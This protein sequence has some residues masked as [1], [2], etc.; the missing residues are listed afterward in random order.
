ME[1]RV[2][3]VCPACAAVNRVPGER[4]KDRALCGR[5]HQPLF[6]GHPL[7]LDAAAFERH[8]S[9]NS[10]P[11]LIDFWAPWCGPCRMMAPAYEQ[12]ARRLEPRVRVAKL[13]T[14]SHP[15]LAQ[16]Y[17]VRSIPTVIL[18]EHGREKARQSGAMGL[19]D[20][21]SWVQPQL[22]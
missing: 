4:L 22:A 20:L 11:M 15:Q 19:D 2:N 18:F 21:L 7:E 6:S 9:R 16:R 3:I 8:L 17:A 5:C 1:E 13:D 14:E 12:A 10:V